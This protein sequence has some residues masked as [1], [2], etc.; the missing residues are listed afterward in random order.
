MSDPGPSFSLKVPHGEDRERR[1]CDTCGFVDYVNPR[2]VAG[3][4]VAWSDGAAPFGPNAAP[5]ARIR[6]LLCRRA[7]NPRKGWWT[8]PAG[9]MESGETVADA[10]RREAWEEAR[11][12]LELDALL[13]V[14]D[15]PHI[16]QV[17]IFH[18]AALARA[19]VSPGPE[20]LETALFAW[21]EIPWGELAF[22]SVLWSLEAFAETRELSAFQPRRN[23][24]EV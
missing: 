15:V 6:I 5:L 18:R 21:D 11:A 9:F 13:A 2:I 22:P 20:S 3:A 24:G 8:L 16:S 23:P 19:D 1:V 14:Y 12:E 17:Q 4:V 10:V 7:I